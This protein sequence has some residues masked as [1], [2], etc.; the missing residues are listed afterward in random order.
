MSK[1]IQ[2]NELIK[3]KT[4]L[5]KN[6]IS[7]TTDTRFKIPADTK[8]QAFIKWLEISVIFDSTIDDILKTRDWRDE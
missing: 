4:K 6:F 1:N 2:V 7:T 3:F 8:S 5:Q